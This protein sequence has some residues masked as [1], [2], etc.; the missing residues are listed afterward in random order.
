MTNPLPRTGFS[1][2]SFAVNPHAKNL[3]E[4]VKIN[5]VTEREE[6]KANQIVAKILESAEIEVEKAAQQE[7]DYERLAQSEAEAAY[8]SNKAVI[9][10]RYN[11]GFE[12]PPRDES[13]L[14]DRSIELDESQV[15]AVDRLA[16]VQYG[17]LIGAAGTGKTTVQKYLIQRLIYGNGD[18]DAPAIRLKRLESKAFNIALVAFT[19]MA[20]QVIKSNLPEW[21]GGAASTIHGLLEFAPEEHINKRGET[22][23]IFMPQ[24]HQFNKL[25]IDVLIIDEASMLGLEL[26]KQ[27]LDALKPGTRIYMTGDL[28]QLP[29]IIGQPIFAYALSHWTVAELTKVHRQKE[30]GANRIVEVAHQILNGVEPTFDTSEGNPHWRV[31]GFNL[32]DNVKKA[33][34]Q[35]LAILN[36]VRKMKVHPDADPTQ[37][38]IYDPYRDR[39]M[40]A[41]NGYD[42]NIESSMVQQHPINE[43]LSMLIQPPDEE[44]QRIIIDAG[45]SHKKFAVNLRVMATKNESMNQENRVTNGLTGRIL[46]IEPNANYTGDSR[47]F[48]PEEAIKAHIKSALAKGGIGNFGTTLGQVDEEKPNLSFEDDFSLDGTELQGGTPEEQVDSSGIASH[49]VHVAFDNGAIRKYASKAGVD[50]LQLAYA[51]TVAKCQGSQFDTAIIVVHPAQ[52]GQLSREWLYTAVTRATKRVIILKTSYGMRLAIN[53]QKIVG[54]TIAEKVLRY[55]EMC[56]EAGVEAGYGARMR[57]NVPLTIETYDPS[58]PTYERVK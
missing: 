1:L 18:G 19:G 57:V 32:D 44:H 5:G 26:W 53:R 41:G 29:P 25:D 6:A 28:N 38:L 35:I 31:I 10:S 8:E 13:G 37:P 17:C 22:S 14:Y 11:G 48:G 56:S 39:V 9:E 42:E 4:S 34:T 16:N 52:K 3:A 23:R 54:R 24:R 51:S 27:L 36:Q 7:A 50:S 46:A 47:R 2:S 58:I 30:A 20:S 12:L 33:F 45:R 43:A 49:T 40:T 55:Y 21:L 15:V